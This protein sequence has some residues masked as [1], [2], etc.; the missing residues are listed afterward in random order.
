MRNETTRNVLYAVVYPIRQLGATVILGL[1]IVYIFSMLQFLNFPKDFEGFEC[2]SLGSCF[3]ATLNWGS[4]NGGG[5][6]ESLTEWSVMNHFDQWI[7]R[8][9]VYNIVFF[10]IV[11]V[12]LLNVIFGIIIDTFGELRQNKN[13]KD[14]DMQERCFICNID[15]ST[16]ERN[17]KD[18][19]DHIKE[20]HCMWDY[21]KYVVHLES[22]DKGEYSGLEDY[23]YAQINS[24]EIDFFPVG[25]C[26]KLTNLRE[27]ER[28]D[29]WEEEESETEKS[30]TEQ[31]LLEAIARDHQLT[32]N[33][34][35]GLKRV[36]IAGEE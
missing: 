13:E 1:F 25:R 29:F 26:Q 2:Q 5:V 21:V 32:T 4:R 36:A 9:F 22:K 15:R 16:F 3:L 18:F 10:L 17:L 23:I 30:R 31:I 35:R 33:Q 6:G 28:E 20:E 14:A 8:N 27:D 7:N 19:S 34:G 11:N 24:M 12:I